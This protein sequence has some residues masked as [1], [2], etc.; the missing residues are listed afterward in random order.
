[1]QLSYKIFFSV[2]E[3]LFLEL[4]YNIILVLDAKTHWFDVFIGLYSI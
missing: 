2:I 4:I 3:T 1:M